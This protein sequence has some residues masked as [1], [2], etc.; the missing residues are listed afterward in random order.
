MA[1]V[2]R[3]CQHDNADEYVLVHVSSSGKEDLDLEL[4]GTEG[5]APYLYSCTC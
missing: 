4:V 3:V 1:R 2:L 5:N